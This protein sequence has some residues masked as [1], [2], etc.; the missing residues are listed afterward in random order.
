MCKEETEDETRIAFVEGVTRHMR[1]GNGDPEDTVYEEVESQ[2]FYICEARCK[3]PELDAQY[4]AGVR[5]FNIIAKKSTVSSK[6]IRCLNCGH[7]QKI[8][9]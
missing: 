7:E 8:G 9:A 5:S 4:G 3:N 2:M 6:V 1:E